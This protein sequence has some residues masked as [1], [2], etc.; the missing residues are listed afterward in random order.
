MD[1]NIKNMSKAKQRDNLIQKINHQLNSKET[2]IDY[3]TKASF[4]REFDGLKSG[5]QIKS[6]E[7]Y[8]SHFLLF[9]F[10]YFPIFLFEKYFS[11]GLMTIICSKK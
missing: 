9:K 2:V 7:K 4:K 5:K 6:L 3:R 11:F 1:S 10:L 8:F